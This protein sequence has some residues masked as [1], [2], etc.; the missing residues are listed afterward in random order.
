MNARLARVETRVEQIQVDLA[1]VK[2]DVRELRT[3]IREL[4]NHARED[5]RILFGAQIVASLG[6]AA[7]VAK[8]FGWL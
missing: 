1:S 6:V 2:T 8:G 4:R 5:F 3:D 7:V